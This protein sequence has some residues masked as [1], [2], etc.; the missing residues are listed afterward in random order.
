LTAGFQS[1]DL[2]RSARRALRADV[3]RPALVLS[4]R[5][6]EHELV[7]GARV[8]LVLIGGPRHGVS[9]VCSL[10]PGVV[11]HPG[12]QLLTPPESP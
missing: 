6:A 8:R 9:E 4:P 11:L 2:P 7:G 1:P 5:V 12:Q 10:G 3:H